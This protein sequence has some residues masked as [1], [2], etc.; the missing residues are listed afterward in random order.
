MLSKEPG[1]IVLRFYSAFVDRWISAG[2]QTQIDVPFYRYIRE[3][4]VVDN[5]LGV[6]EGGSIST[7]I[8]PSLSHTGG[9]NEMRIG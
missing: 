7:P 6:A 4:R 3:T 1:K 2:T 8:F 9:A 5:R